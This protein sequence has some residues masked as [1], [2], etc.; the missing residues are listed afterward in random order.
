MS[1]GFDNRVDKISLKDECCFEGS[2]SLGIS[3]KHM[4]CIYSLF[5]FLKEM[6]TSSAL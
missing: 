1:I 4:Y 2:S 5:P 6:M 3:I